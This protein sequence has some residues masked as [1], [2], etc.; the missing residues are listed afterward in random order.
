MN[1]LSRLES[2]SIYILREAFHHFESLAM[3]WSVGEDSNVILW[4]A[5][6]AF[7]GHTPFPLVHRA[8]RHQLRDAGVDYLP[9]PARP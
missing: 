5:R 3:L 2:Q 4:L 8:S 9:R 1:H 7:F 6:K